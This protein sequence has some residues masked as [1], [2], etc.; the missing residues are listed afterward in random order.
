MNATLAYALTIGSLVAMCLG[1][2]GSYLIGVLGCIVYAIALI[3]ALAAAAMRGDTAM[4][5]CIIFVP[6]VG[7]FCAITKYCR[8]KA[9]VSESTLTCLVMLGF[10]GG[11]AWA[12]I[13]LMRYAWITD[14]PWWMKIIPFVVGLVLTLVGIYVLLFSVIRKQNGK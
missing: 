6:I 3:C 14:C 7:V 10:S 11:L 1:Y 9:I 2:N 13:G 4:L 12:G 5:L 8:D